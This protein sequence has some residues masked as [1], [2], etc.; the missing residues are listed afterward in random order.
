MLFPKKWSG[1][2]GGVCVQRVGREPGICKFFFF[3]KKYHLT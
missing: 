2:G 3:K 1:C